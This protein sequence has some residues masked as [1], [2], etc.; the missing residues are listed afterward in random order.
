MLSII[1]LFPILWPLAIILAL[2][3]HRFESIRPCLET[4][5][6][7]P[8]L[9]QLL[10]TGRAE[11]DILAEFQH[12]LRDTTM[13]ELGVDAAGCNAALA[14]SRKEWIEQDDGDWL[15]AH[16]FY[17]GACAAARELLRAGR[18]D[19][20]FVIT[21]KAA[22]FTR[23]LLAEQR[24][25]GPAAPGGGIAAAHIYGLGSGPK[26]AVLEQLLADRGPGAAAVF[27]EDRLLTLDQTVAAAGLAGRVLP[28]LAGWG[29]NTAGQKA[30][31]AA[32]QYV[33]LQQPAEL[34]SVL[35]LSAAEVA[36]RLEESRSRAAAGRAASKL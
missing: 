32:Q 2:Q 13:A 21:T 28:V 34:S 9:L 12:G 27:V 1:P 25:F 29:Y 17:G 15:Q 4:G 8:L 5:W 19:D 7:A 35:G 11:A 36:A 16:G 20:L 31:A 24:L 33:V 14:A 18:A 3:V 22:G 23:R 6:E 26:P 30:A 10:A